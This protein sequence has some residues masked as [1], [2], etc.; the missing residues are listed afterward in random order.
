M[1]IKNTVSILTKGLIL[2]LVIG[3][4]LLS[5]Q[6]LYFKI[7]KRRKNSLSAR[8]WKLTAFTSYIIVVLVVTLLSRSFSNTSINMQL[9]RSHRKALVTLNQSEILYLILNVAMTIPLGFLLP[10]LFKKSKRLVFLIA[11]TL[12][13]ILPI[14]LLQLLLHRGIFD[15]DDIFNNLLGSI[16]GYS[17]FQLFEVFNKK[18]FK[19]KK[20]LFILPILVTLI[21]PYALSK[22]IHSGTYGRLYFDYGNVK[23]RSIDINFNPNI[24][25]TNI[26]VSGTNTKTNIANTK[27][28]KINRRSVKSGMEWFQTITKQQFQED[29]ITVTKNMYDINYKLNDYTS[30]IFN[31]SHDDTNWTLHILEDRNSLDVINRDTLQIE[32]ENY[33][34]EVSKNSTFIESDDG[35][36]FSLNDK[37]SL[38]ENNLFN[39]TIT[40]TLLN[41]YIISIY[42]S[43]TVGEPFDEV[44]LNPLSSIKEEFLKGNYLIYDEAKKDSIEIYINTVEVDYVL[45]RKD[46]LQPVYRV[47]Y[48]IDGMDYELLYEAIS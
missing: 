10:V 47:K 36:T 29:H 2:F 38:V 34:I 45:D 17:L 23:T 41:G 11:S 46:I 19:L 12:L 16:I 8:Q 40:T 35:N 31:T 22:Q 1:N 33:D 48:I 39:Q 5:L 18:D 30:F 26:T 6:Y 27:T 24:D 21:F 13:I 20:L 44:Q 43:S 15:I 42:Y 37:N 28:Y 7:M 32:L 14:E 9:F 3:F 25:T 4:L